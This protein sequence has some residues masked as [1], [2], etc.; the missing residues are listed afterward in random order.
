MASISRYKLHTS[1]SPF[2]D[3]VLEFSNEENY[4]YRFFDKTGDSYAVDTYDQ[5]N[6]YVQFSSKSTTI[7]FITGS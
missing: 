1:S 7:A 5:D 3:Y 2:F 6:H 4:N